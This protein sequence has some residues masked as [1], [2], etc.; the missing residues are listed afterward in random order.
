MLSFYLENLLQL[1]NNFFQC[2][3]AKKCIIYKLNKYIC[4]ALLLKKKGGFIF[5]D[6]IPNAAELYSAIFPLIN[7][8]I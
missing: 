7:S 1:T 8:Y 3:K 5:L 4:T 2:L 6:F